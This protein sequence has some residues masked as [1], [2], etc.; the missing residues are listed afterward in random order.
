MRALNEKYAVAVRDN[1][2]LK[3]LLRETVLKENQLHSLVS[4]MKQ[5]V[6]DQKSHILGLVKEKESQ[7]RTTEDLQRQL[8]DVNHS[9]QR[10]QDELV[11]KDGDIELLQREL[12]AADSSRPK[13]VPYA[14]GAN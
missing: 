4:Q 13:Q 8:R 11:R 5:M 12:R 14:I 3:E 9:L 1:A 2:D 10:L 7:N 6:S